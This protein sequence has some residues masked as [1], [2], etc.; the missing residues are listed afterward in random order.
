M[1]PL[2]RRFLRFNPTG[3]DHVVCVLFMGH[4]ALD[5]TELV[6]RGFRADPEVEK[7]PTPFHL[8]RIE[9]FPEVG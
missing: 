2:A 5:A 8:G 7:P 6:S 3:S 9:G 1:L 4:V